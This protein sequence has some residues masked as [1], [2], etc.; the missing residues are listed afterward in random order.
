MQRQMQWSCV[1]GYSQTANAITTSLKGVLPKQ[2]R[3]DRL[4]EEGCNSENPKK[5]G[6]PLDP[7]CPYLKKRHCLIWDCTEE[8]H[9]STIMR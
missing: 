1:W 7:L 6:P 2:A 9:E 4:H 3:S 8:L 5:A